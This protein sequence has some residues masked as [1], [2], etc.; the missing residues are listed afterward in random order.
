MWA[1]KSKAGGK[2]TERRSRGGL[3]P[4][5]AP[6]SIQ[7]FSLLKVLGQGSFGKVFLG[8]VKAT[9]ER[10]AIKVLKKHMVISN[11]DVANTM[12]ERR[13]LSLG[14]EGECDFLAGLQMSFQVMCGCSFSLYA[15]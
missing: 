9:K 5:S 7:D 3:P 2:H 8:E 4:R 15:Y 14:T 6:R 10:F 13:I 1:S 11:H 12:V